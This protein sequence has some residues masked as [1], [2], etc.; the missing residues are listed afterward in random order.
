M[1]CRET[2]DPDIHADANWQKPSIMLFTSSVIGL[3]FVASRSMSAQDSDTVW[4]LQ[5]KLLQSLFEIWTENR[6]LHQ[7]PQLQANIYLFLPHLLLLW[8]QLKSDRH[9]LSVSHKTLIKHFTAF[10]V[11]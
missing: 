10:N 4:W 3:N 1:S 6:F 8:V 5:K 7:R 2:L 11:I 9:T